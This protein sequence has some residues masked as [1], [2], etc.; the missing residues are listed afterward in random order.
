VVHPCRLRQ[1]FAKWEQ[2]KAKHVSL[3]KMFLDFMS[4]DAWDLSLLR[5]VAVLLSIYPSIA[6]HL[7]NPPSLSLTIFQVSALVKD[8]VGLE[9]LD[10]AMKKFGMPV[11]PIT[12]AD[13]V[14]LDVTYHVAS[15]LSKADLGARMTGGDAGLMGKMVEKGW[16]GKKTGQGFFTYDKKKKTINS[17]VKKFVSE[18]ATK[19]L[20]L[21]EEEIQN[22]IVSRFVNE[23]VKC[24]EDEII[25]D[26]VAGDIGLVF[27]TGFAPFRGGPF[28]YLDTVGISSYVGMMNK[29]ADTYGPQFEPCALL[30]DY[31]S[32]GKKFHAKK[33]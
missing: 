7:R 13:E 11:G 29:F 3:L 24:L 32:S 4:I 17:E 27:G 21:S 12:L 31:A 23:A 19:K 8:G 33:M 20:N 25:T 16:L 14:G 28:R 18:F 2:S 10:K 30:Q 5:Y 15:F 22:R 6:T 9:V 26:P 1:L